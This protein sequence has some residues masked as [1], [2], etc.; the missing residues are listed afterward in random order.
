MAPRCV[1]LLLLL[2]FISCSS[3]TVIEV[4]GDPTVI[5]SVALIV[6]K[7]SYPTS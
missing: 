5:G 1:I 2:L 6:S 3:F 4:D 7:N